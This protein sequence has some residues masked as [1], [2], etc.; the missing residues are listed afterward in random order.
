VPICQPPFAPNYLP[1]SKKVILS[2]SAVTNLCET[3]AN[4]VATLVGLV[5]LL[6]LARFARF[7]RF[8]G[9][10]LLGAGW[11]WVVW[12]RVVRW[13]WWIVF[14]GHSVGVANS[15]TSAH[16]MASLTSLASLAS[17]ARFARFARFARLA[18]FLGARLLGAG[19]GRVVWLRIMWR[20]RGIVFRGHGVGVASSDISAD[21][22][23]SLARLARLARLAGFLGA[24]FLG[25]GLLGAG[26]RWIVWLRVVWWW[27][28]RIVFRSPSVSVANGNISTNI[29]AALARLSR[30]LGS[31]LLGARFLGARLLG[32][33][34]R[35]VI[36]LRV[37][38]RGGGIVFRG[39]RIGISDS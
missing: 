30:F 15:N 22:V 1:A 39:H 4:I 9:A 34:W 31:G 18:R 25:A 21:I 35:R 29:V 33:G 17:L 10:R 19:G 20:R 12:L 3:S 23:T 16:V 28:R 32:A 14:R 11:G 5:R 24:R 38:W 2:L 8:L 6:R 26:W 13:W 7:A 36:W 37:V 27:W